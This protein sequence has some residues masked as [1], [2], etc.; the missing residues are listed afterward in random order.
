MTWS[1]IHWD[2]FSRLIDSLGHFPFCWF[3]V[4]SLP[5]QSVRHVI[6]P[7]HIT[8]PQN[9]RQPLSPYPT[10]TTYIQLEKTLLLWNRNPDD[11]P[12]PQTIPPFRTPHPPLPLFPSPKDWTSNT[13]FTP[14]CQSGFL[15]ESDYPLL[16]R[17]AFTQ[18]ARFHVYFR[19]PHGCAKTQWLK[20]VIANMLH[21]SW[22]LPADSK[23]KFFFFF[24]YITH[25]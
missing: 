3:A 1:F 19:L 7:I 12:V 18:I 8:T 11:S 6:S 20:R 24:F 15:P 22:F 2:F 9:L 21:K 4:V 16:S 5:F 13:T 10:S 25:S 14:N 23:R 17:T